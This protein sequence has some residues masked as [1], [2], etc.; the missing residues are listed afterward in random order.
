MARVIPAILAVPIAVGLAA[1][2]QALV[3]FLPFGAALLLA[4][5]WAGL[6]R[7]LGVHVRAW[8]LAA[9]LVAIGAYSAYHL[10]PGSSAGLVFAM[11][12]VMVGLVSGPGPGLAT[13]VLT[14]ACLIAFGIA[15]RVPSG[16]YVAAHLPLPETWLRAAGVYAVTTGL[17]LL[18][19]T[20]AVRRV[21]GAEADAR[22]NERWLRLT[23]DSADQATWS[24]DV[25]TRTFTW[26]PG[27][28]APN[29]MPVH[30]V[31]RSFEGVM[32]WI[33]PDD[34]AA[35]G[36]ALADVMGG[37]AR[38]YHIEHRVCMPGADPVWIEA[39]ARLHRVAGKDVLLGTIADVTAR[40]RA[41]ERRAAAQ[42]ALLDLTTRDA[43]GD[44]DA[45]I[46]EIV[47]VGAGILGVDRCAYWRLDD[48]GLAGAPAGRRLS[49][50]ACA[51]FVAA[52]RSRRT[53]A[54]EDA[55][56]DDGTRAVA[57]E[58]G[59]AALLAAPVHI[60]GRLVG[61]LC[62]EH[63]AAPRRW[64][65][66]DASH[67]AS[68]ADCVSR[69]IEASERARAEAQL[70]RAY[71][72]LGQLTRR[73][74]AAKEEE[75]RRI[76]RE[77]HDELGQTLTALKLNL[78]LLAR[79]PTGGDRL[80]QSIDIVDRSIQATRELARG[81]RPPLFDEIG[82]V[83]ALQA[84][85]DE[86][87]RC[88]DV[89]FELTAPPAD[90]R[91]PPE[92]EMAAFRIVQ[93][94]VT[95]VLRHARARRV[96]VELERERHAIDIAVRDDGRGFDVNDAFGRAEAGGHLGLVGMRE[97]ASALGGTFDVRSAAGRGT[98]IHVRLPAE[99]DA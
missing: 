75:R 9:P 3:S 14:S 42:A 31:P 85:L 16:A 22:A 95:N 50:D 87:A 30:L 34:R 33:H 71:A 48:A 51:P 6:S 15:G 63:A 36:A 82:L 56:A 66:D 26:D 23:L 24:L 60:G 59:V 12:T 2:P 4:S 20:R 39:R 88:S 10:G 43:R 78:S 79:D 38:E 86:Q 58:L 84:F 76:S 32:A 81:M 96:T 55:L 29:A 68:L 77:L 7:T 18:L 27:T 99:G 62:H 69:A 47:D 37:G 11:A 89:A 8:V 1:H 5:L 67:A 19:A 25:A 97:R 13:L 91:G 53:L 40:R 80:R 92:I 65:A 98:E 64:T 49:A 41:E 74:E 61:V 44:L 72:Q 57:A 90:G 94:A 28:V 54:A 21:E 35:V 93:E 73:L 17:L 52:L 83:P 70:K 46:A 45:A